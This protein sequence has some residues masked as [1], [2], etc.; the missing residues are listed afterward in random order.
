[1]RISKTRVSQDPVVYQLGFNLIQLIL[2]FCSFNEIS[3]FINNSHFGWNFH[4]KTRKKPTHCDAATI[5]IWADYH[6]FQHFLFF[7]I[8]AILNG[9]YS[10]RTQIW[11]E[12]MHGP[13]MTSLV[14]LCS[15]GSKE[16]IQM[17]FLSKTAQ[18]T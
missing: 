11:K 5:Q 17:W 18:F 6:E 10:F 12:T 7:V 4:R 8:S 15:V 14:C 16:K 1:M 13:S 9:R 3:T 2:F